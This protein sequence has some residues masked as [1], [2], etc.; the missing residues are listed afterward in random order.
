M[1]SF[2][3]Q[4]IDTVMGIQVKEK[5]IA[6]SKA[7]EQRDKAQLDK[8]LH[9]DFRVVANQYPT[10]DKLTTLTKDVYISLIEA[11][12]IGG[13]SYNVEFDYVS[14]EEHSATVIAKFEGKQSSMYL[15]LLLI[16]HDDNWKIIEDMA[17]FK[18]NEA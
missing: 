16:K 4:K 5:V 17:L 10:K 12:K 13:A 8:L 15:T 2:T 9:K 3:N 6:F 7:I 1:Y 11:K 14:V 18:K